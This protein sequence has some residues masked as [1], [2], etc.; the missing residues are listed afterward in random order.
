MKNTTLKN[1]IL[2]FDTMAPDHFTDWFKENKKLLLE[3]EAKEHEEIRNDTFEEA[4]G[5]FQ[6]VCEQHG[7]Q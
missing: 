2:N 6:D 1:I 4:H 7:F 3:K 5:Q